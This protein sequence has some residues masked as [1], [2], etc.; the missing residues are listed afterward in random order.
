MSVLEWGVSKGVSGIGGVEFYTED[1]VIAGG[2]IEGSNGVVEWSVR[3]MPWDV[4][5][6][7]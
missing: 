4:A 3:L 2:E 1:R 6:G 7:Q 5:V